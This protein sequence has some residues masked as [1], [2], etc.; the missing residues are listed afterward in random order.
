MN[1]LN[2]TMSRTTFARSMRRALLP[3]FATGLACF[4]VTAAAQ[5]QYGTP[6]VRSDGIVLVQTQSAMPYRGVRASQMIGMSVRNRAG[7]NIGQIDDMVVDMNSGD[8]RYAMLRFDPGITRAEKLF[9]VP[10]Q[11]LRI[12]PDRNDVIFD[13]D[14]DRLERAS[15]DRSAWNDRVVAAPG[16]TDR[17][18]RAW[19]ITQPSRDAMAHRVSDLIGKDVNNLDGNEV[20]EVED[21]VINMATSQVHYAV[22]DFDSG[23]ASPVT[24]YAVPLRMLSLSRDGDDLVLN[25]DQAA[26]QRLMAFPQE[27]W[28]NLNDGVWVADVDRYLVVVP[29]ATV[30]TVAPASR[31][32]PSAL[33]NRLDSNGSDSIDIYE[34]ADSALVDRNWSTFDADHNRFISRQEFSRQ[35]P[36]DGSGELRR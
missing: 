12:A 11:Q 4:A 28:A 3:A 24:D 23:A 14:V 16:F 27:R 19:G 6:P 1:R 2:R 15:I 25:A 7:Q 31:E 10:T 33:F 20:G 29:V 21:L 17:F 13:M 22:V 35:F 18:D 36:D 26:V 5:I 30:T 9:A 8:V 32:T 34:A